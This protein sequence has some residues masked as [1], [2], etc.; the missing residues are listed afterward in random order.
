MQPLKKTVNFY[1]DM[2]NVYDYKVKKM[3]RKVVYKKTTNK[4]NYV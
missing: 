4:K 2:E 1:N 3:T